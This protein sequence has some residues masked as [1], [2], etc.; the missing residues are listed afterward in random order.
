M[1]NAL[2]M[3]AEQPLNVVVSSVGKVTQR[4][5][6]KK[7]AY[8]WAV[9]FK[10][11]QVDKLVAPAGLVYLS[12]DSPNVM[13]KFDPKLAKQ[14]ELRDRGVGGQEPAKGRKHETG[15]ETGTENGPFS[16]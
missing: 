10:E 12:P 9:N 15:G 13:R 8:K 1:I 7:Q 2:Q 6:A 3:K 16:A 11:Q 14:S 4:M 5:L